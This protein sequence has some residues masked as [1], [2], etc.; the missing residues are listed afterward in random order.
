MDADCL[1]ILI[2][3]GGPSKRLTAEV[4]LPAFG[5]AA[6]LSKRNINLHRSE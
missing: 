3:F 6:A 4:T 2:F 5:G 1:P